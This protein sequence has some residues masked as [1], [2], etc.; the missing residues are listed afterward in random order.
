M[1]FL[2]FPRS[3]GARRAGPPIRPCRIKTKVSTNTFVLRRLEPQVQ[4]EEEEE[5][6]VTFSFH[7]VNSRGLYSSLIGTKWPRIHSGNGNTAMGRSHRD[8]PLPPVL[9]GMWSPTSVSV[10]FPAALPS[11]ARV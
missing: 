5:E 8:P 11:G 4:E 6:E 10:S 2:P 3:L 9:G 7:E 1:W